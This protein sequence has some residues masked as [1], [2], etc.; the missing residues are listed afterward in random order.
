MP[1]RK[2]TVPQQAQRADSPSN[3]TATGD[4]AGSIADELDLLLMQHASPP[5]NPA[6]INPAAVNPA[7]TTTTPALLQQQSAILQP[8]HIQAALRQQQ[9]LR[10]Q[11]NRTTSNQSIAT[12]PT[13][14]TSNQPSTQPTA[15]PSSTTSNP[16]PFDLIMQVLPDDQRPA[17]HALIQALKRRLLSADQFLLQ[18]RERFGQEIYEYIN[19]KRTMP[20]Q[21]S[22]TGNEA[23]R[24]DTRDGKFTNIQNQSKW[25]TSATSIPFRLYLCY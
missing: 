2:S 25:N 9:I 4:A 17:F 6:A 5:V 18:V 3:T 24:Q 8:A 19:R 16:T 14:T 1:R 20:A 12:P 10:Q 11:L 7:T 22:N 23:K 21:S 13:T 15:A